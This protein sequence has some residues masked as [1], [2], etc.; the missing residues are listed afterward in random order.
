MRVAHRVTE[1][2]VEGAVGDDR[3]GERSDQRPNRR[4][5]PAT[6]GD[7]RRGQPVRDVRLDRRLAQGGGRAVGE[8]AGAEHG[9]AGVGENERD[10][11]Q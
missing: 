5:L 8:R 9:S 2:R 4:E 3:A 11:D 7:H 1:Q 10:D 6:A